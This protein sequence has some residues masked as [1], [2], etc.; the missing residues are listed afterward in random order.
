MD[1]LQSR[2]ENH[3]STKKSLSDKLPWIEAEDVAET[4]YLHV[5]IL[6]L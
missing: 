2:Q 1:V 4:A 3:S 6:G 5:H